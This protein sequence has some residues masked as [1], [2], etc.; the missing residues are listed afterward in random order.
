MYHGKRP[1]NHCP[2]TRVRGQASTF[3]GQRAKVP[4][5]GTKV[6]R[7]CPLTRWQ[8]SKHT[9]KQASLHP[10]SETRRREAV[11]S[12][13]ASK[14]RELVPS[15]VVIKKGIEPK[16]DPCGDPDRMVWGPGFSFR[17]SNN[18][19]CCYTHTLN[20]EEDP[21]IAQSLRKTSGQR[22]LR[23]RPRTRR[24]RR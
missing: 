18:R 15:W 23:Q 21:A 14:K 8:T 16:F 17:T 4:G 6:T 3:G 1:E 19:L 24:S 5:P 13:N 9:R 2:R 12:I 10:R 7:S 20:W 11:A 22:C